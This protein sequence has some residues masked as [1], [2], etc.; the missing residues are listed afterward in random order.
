[1][2][3]IKKIAGWLPALAAAAINCYVFFWLY[4]AEPQ[5]LGPKI[6]SMTI[7]T[8]F[9]ILVLLWWGMA[10]AALAC[11]TGGPH[12][13]CFAALLPVELL[14][15]L[16][17]FRKMWLA[18]VLLAALWLAG[19]V[20]FRRRS[21]Q[22][23]RQKKSR[24]SDFDFLWAEDRLRNICRRFGVLLAVI[25]LA[26]PAAWGAWDHLADARGPSMLES[27]PQVAEKED[28]PT[29]FLS[30]F[31]NENWARADLSGRTSLLEQLA[32]YELAVLG[33]PADGIKFS[34]RELSEDLCGYYGSSSNQLVLN[35]SM[36]EEQ[37]RRENIN[38]VAHEAFH[39]QQIYVVEHVN[40]NDAAANAA[41]YDQA[42][43]WLRNYQEG[44][45]QMEEDVWGYYRQPVEADARK[46]AGEETDRLWDLVRQIE[47]ENAEDS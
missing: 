7:A 15:A 13:L 22:R 19:M 45:V 20:W 42:R 31:T 9:T 38:T 21:T 18:G 1:M 46:Y 30:G 29:D 39:A 33:V 24:Y 11:M 3:E 5:L 4:W 6:P 17:V 8:V 36:V 32:T 43:R 25:L 37:A 28:Y 23:L 16:T 2:A 27:L 12:F 40:W 44:Y 35:K 34:V 14:F 41:Y 26:V 10:P 47:Q